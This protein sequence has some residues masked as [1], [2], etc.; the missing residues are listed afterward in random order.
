VSKRGNARLGGRWSPGASS[1]QT[2]GRLQLLSS[3]N[4]D[5]LVGLHIL[6]LLV[7]HI[8]MLVSFR[9]LLLSVDELILENLNGALPGSH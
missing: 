1:V 4:V 9:E 7:V 8:Q 3:L 6:D 5:I 2:G